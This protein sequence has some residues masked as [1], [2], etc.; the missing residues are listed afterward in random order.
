M[1]EAAEGVRLQKVL[2]NVLAQQ[3]Q[4]PQMPVCQT[5]ER[6]PATARVTV[7]EVDASYSMQLLCEVCAA[8]HEE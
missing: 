7:R 8:P 5:C 4:V 3:A 6:R 1:T 2:A